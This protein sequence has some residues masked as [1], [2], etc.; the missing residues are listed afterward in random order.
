MT[1][2]KATGKSQNPINAQ[3]PPKFLAVGQIVR[4]HGVRGNLLV[5]ATSQIIKSI[6]PGTQVFL[7]PKQQ[8][9]TVRYLSSHHDQYLL[10]LEAL[11][12]RE[13]AEAY[14]G[15]TLFIRF[16]DTS[17]L[18]EDSYYHWQLLGLNVV[19]DQG[20]NLGN[21][22]EIIETGAND[23]YLIH[24]HTGSEL[25]LPAIKSV[26]Q[27]IDLEKKLMVVHLLP[28]LEPSTS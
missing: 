13:E 24:S 8:A 3:Q 7:G 11:N 9:F 25:L 18:A 15:G 22:E 2:K 5:A 27:S 20:E 1:R 16:E 28:G 26:I 19:S 23:V 4:P 10:S 21:L 14:R 12:L 17:P 6:I